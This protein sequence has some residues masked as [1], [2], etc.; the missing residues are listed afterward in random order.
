MP[1]IRETD[2]MR[3]FTLMPIA[4]GMERLV[5]MCM[6]HL[7]T[8]TNYAEDNQ[9]VWVE[10]GHA[11]ACDMTIFSQTL[12]KLYKLADSFNNTIT[13]DEQRTQSHESEVVPPQGHVKKNSI[14][15]IKYTGG[16]PPRKL[17]NF[18]LLTDLID[19]SEN[20]YPITYFQEKV[21]Q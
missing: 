14:P 10:L 15:L 17:T 21:E 3:H 5:V 12:T 19:N 16:K 4:S 11:S 9:R 7:L 18:Q 2:P 6:T 20:L 1:A 13:E 8:E